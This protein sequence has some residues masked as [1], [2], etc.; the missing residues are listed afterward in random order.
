MPGC[1]LTIIDYRMTMRSVSITVRGDAGASLWCVDRRYN[2]PSW[3]V[4]RARCDNQLGNADGH[5]SRNVDLDLK[6]TGDVLHLRVLAANRHLDVEHE[7]GQGKT[8]QIA[9][10]GKRAGQTFT[11]SRKNDDIFGLCR[12]VFGLCRVVFAVK[13]TVLVESCRLLSSASPG[14]PN[15]RWAPLPMPPRF[16]TCELSAS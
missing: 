12:V 4:S 6:N 3:T 9:V 15:S 14:S 10:F 13:E 5:P 16:S 2:D 11:G 1:S 7:R 8:D